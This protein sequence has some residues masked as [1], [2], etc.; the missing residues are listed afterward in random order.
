MD[1]AVIEIC[2]SPRFSTLRKLRNASGVGVFG[3]EETDR[4]LL[5]RRSGTGRRDLLRLGTRIWD[6]LPE[7]AESCR[8]TRGVDWLP[9]SGEECASFMKFT[10]L[11]CGLA[12]HHLLL[13][14]S[15]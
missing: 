13:S 6:Q 5:G 4:F 11:L 3:D 7:P 14:L 8:R 10:A 15:T 9:L 12:L 2:D 1:K